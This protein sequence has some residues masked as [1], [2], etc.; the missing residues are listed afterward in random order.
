M[1]YNDSL[2]HKVTD[3]ISFIT[4]PKPIE[5]LAKVNSILFDVDIEN[6]YR[7]K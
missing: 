6:D 3:I 2:V 5:I 1:G 7:F 4:S